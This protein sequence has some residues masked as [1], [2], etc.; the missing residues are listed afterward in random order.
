[1]KKKP[2]AKKMPRKSAKVTF[3]EVH[4][5]PD[6]ETIKNKKEVKKDTFSEH[7]TL[8]EV[9]KSETAVRKGIDNTPDVKV[10]SQLK[11]I[12]RNI[13]SFSV[14]FSTALPASR[15]LSASLVTVF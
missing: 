10:I 12:C 7:F 5:T 11:S 3:K 6:W 4:D 1:M 13:F 8:N 14:A 2:A 15:A 9:I